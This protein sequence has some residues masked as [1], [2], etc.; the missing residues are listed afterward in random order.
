MSDFGEVKDLELKHAELV[1]EIKTLIRRTK[2]T[3]VSP[4]TKVR[5]MIH[6]NITNSTLLPANDTNR[7]INYWI[8][9][10]FNH[11]QGAN[12]QPNLQPEDSV[13]KNGSRTVSKSKA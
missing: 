10:G 4:R 8:Q 11:L 2:L 13:S 9:V 6:K 1:E 7:T 5:S 3:M 12:G